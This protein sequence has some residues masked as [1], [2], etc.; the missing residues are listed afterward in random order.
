MTAIASSPGF[1]PP[2]QFANGAE[3]LAALGDVPLDRIIFDPWPGTATETDLLR[4]IER[5]KHLCELIDGTLVEKP[6]GS[7]EAIIAFRLGGLLMA[8][9]DKHDLGV[10]SGADTPLRMKS[11]RV[12]LPD[13]VFFSKER[14][15]KNLKP[16]LALA[17][18]LVVEVLS[19]GNTVAEMDQ[20]RAEYFQSGTRLV[21]IIDPRP[22]TVAVYHHPGEPTTVLNEQ[23]TLDGEQVLPGL[24]IAVADLFR[25]VPRGE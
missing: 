24:E 9:A 5:D 20:K 8:F 15:P 21:W 4:L 16:I 3:W 22:R 1:R 7:V 14:F 12:R 10:V 6:V 23:S 17:P 13:V 19:E 2:R 25:N 18:D 11:G